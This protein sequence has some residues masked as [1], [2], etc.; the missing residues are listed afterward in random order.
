MWVVR[1]NPASFPS[2]NLLQLWYP[3]ILN[4]EVGDF[5]L[6]Q[7]NKEQGRSE[8]DVPHNV[9]LQGTSRSTLNSIL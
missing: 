1:Y 5:T 2:Q 4:V 9:A 6:L 3:H 7:N 8:F